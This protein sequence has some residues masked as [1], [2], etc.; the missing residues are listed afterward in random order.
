M[1]KSPI[2][3]RIIGGGPVPDVKYPWMAFFAKINN[4]PLVC[5]M[6]LIAPRWL[7]TACHCVLNP[8]NTGY[9][10]AGARGASQAK[11]NCKNSH[12]LYDGSC[13]LRD[14]KRFVPH[15]CYTPSCCDDHDDVCLAELYEDAPVSAA[16]IPEV[17]HSTLNL[18]LIPSLD[19]N[20]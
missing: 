13:V 19:L 4:R 8:S 14:I 7:M 18:V 6:E 3:F 20:Q 10:P 11:F 9:E 2:F 15:P 1:N 12:N 16:L 17:L 5:G